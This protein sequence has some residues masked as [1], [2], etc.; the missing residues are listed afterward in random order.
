[1]PENYRRHFLGKALYREQIYNTKKRG[2]QNEN[3]K[4][5]TIF[6]ELDI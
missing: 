5:K 3:T 2:K 4:L 6:T 1:M